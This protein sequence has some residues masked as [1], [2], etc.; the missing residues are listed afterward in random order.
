MSDSAE[1]AEF[2]CWSNFSFLEGASH[3]EE[4]V[5][6]GLQ[7]GLRGIALTDRD[8]LYG[9]VRFAKAALA[10][11]QFAAMCGA[12]LTLESAESQPIKASRP[13]RPAKE[14]PTDTPRL[15]LIAADKTGYGNLAQLISIAQLRGRK[16]DAR[17]RLDD[18]D[19]R[20][21]G[22]IALSGG[23]NG[24]VEKALLRRDT[25]GAVAL[26]A[27]LRDYFPGRFY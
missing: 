25:G 24:L 4:L 21:D 12:E 5:A 1:Y 18:L 14:V 26:G 2:H 16:R 19:G 11:P 8:G 6:A 7:L 23:R 13:A 27:R 20:T 10:A 9:A 17:L 22:L 3:P 15:V